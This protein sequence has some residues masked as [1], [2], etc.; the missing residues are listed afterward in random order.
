MLRL[1][2]ASVALAAFSWVSS[3]ATEADPPK[4]SVRLVA[5]CSKSKI[6]IEN[7]DT[8]WNSETFRCDSNGQ[9]R[10]GKQKTQ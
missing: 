4:Q 1:F 2:A 6:T 5:Q 7:P 10:V 9:I 8:V 3:N